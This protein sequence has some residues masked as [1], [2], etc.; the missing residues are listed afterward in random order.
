MS[1]DS[2]PEV[3]NHFITKTHLFK[4]TEKFTTKDWKFSD[5]KSYHFHNSAQNIDIIFLISAQNKDCGYSLE[6]P[7]RGVSNED[8]QSLF[9]AEIFNLKIVSFW[10]LSFLYIWIGVLL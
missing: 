6:P 9:W 5:K 1:K 2:F 10:R 4:Y 7:R 8:Q 3:V